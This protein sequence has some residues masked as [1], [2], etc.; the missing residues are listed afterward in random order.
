MCFV[1][2]W[3]Q[4]A[5]ISLYSI[6]WLVCITETESVYCAVRTGS[7]YIIKV[8]CF[9][10]IW[11]QTAIIFLYKINWLFCVTETECVYCAVRTG[12]LYIIQLMCFVW[13]WDQT[14]IISLYNIN[15]LVCITGTEWVYCALRT[16]ILD[17]IE[18]SILTF[19]RIIIV[20]IIIV[21]VGRDSSVG[22]AT[23]YGLVVRGSNSNGGEIFRIL[24]DRPWGPPSLLYNGY[25]V[26]PRD[27]AAGAWRWPPTPSNAEV[28]ERV[29]L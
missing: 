28:K 4:T 14:A 13:I 16:G 5:I 20:V 25:R 10:W 11:E 23:H 17:T 18:G 2:I 26:F 15:W 29:E 3:E 22:I 21:V 1:W 24:P 27:K 12:C 9:V 8:M 19:K 7:L 6:N